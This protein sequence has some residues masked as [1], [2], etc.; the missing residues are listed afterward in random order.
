MQHCSLE[1]FKSTLPSLQSC[2]EPMHP[3]VASDYRVRGCRELRRAFGGR[4]DRCVRVGGSKIDRIRRHVGSVPCG[5]SLYDA[6]T[7]EV[8]RAENTF[9]SRARNDIRQRE[10]TGNDRDDGA[11]R[12]YLASELDA[13]ATKID[14]IGD[15][16]LSH[17]VVF[18]RPAKTWPKSK[19]LCRYLPLP[20]LRGAHRD[21]ARARHLRRTDVR[22]PQGQ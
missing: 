17:C 18:R 10:V 8:Q 1:A 6:K 13:E 5:Y 3:Q 21:G 22:Q 16:G 15:E 19:M 9:R 4:T 12:L 7:V 14:R 20:L 11:Q 2:L